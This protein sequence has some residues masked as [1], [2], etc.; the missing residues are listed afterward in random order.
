MI[1][2]ILAVVALAGLDTAGAYFAAEVS[3]RKA[4]HMYVLGIAAFVLLFLV[5]SQSL[6]WAELTSVTI[7]WIVVLQFSVMALDKFV[8]GARFS[9]AQCVAIGIA[10]TACAFV[11]F[12]SPG[13]EG[14]V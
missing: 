6:K 14:D 10:L 9:V 12:S 7:G 4:W 3:Q 8:Y 13:T 2:P 1:K 11:M 5:Y